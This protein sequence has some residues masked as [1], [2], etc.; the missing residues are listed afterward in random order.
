M[1]FGMQNDSLQQKLKAL[2]QQFVEYD[3]E[4]NGVASIRQGRCTCAITKHDGRAFRDKARSVIFWF[5]DLRF[6]R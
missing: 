2:D 1:Q 6:A 5:S 4:L 3:M